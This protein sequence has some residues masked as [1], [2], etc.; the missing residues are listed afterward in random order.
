MIRENDKKFLLPSDYE[1]KYNINLRRE[2]AKS[3]INT[4]QRV[5]THTNETCLTENELMETSPKKSRNNYFS[6]KPQDSMNNIISYKYAPN[7][8]EV[9][10]ISFILI[11]FLG[12]YW[13]SEYSNL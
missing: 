3:H 4:A 11:L 7:F 12:I 8:R 5:I 2:R 13:E 9:V 10:K 6:H 1:R